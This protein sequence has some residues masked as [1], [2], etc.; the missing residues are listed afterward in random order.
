MSK[1][2]HCYCKFPTKEIVVEVFS[3]DESKL[4]ALYIVGSHLW[5][6]CNKKSDIDFVAVVSDKYFQDET[7]SINCHHGN[8]EAFIVSVSEYQ[9]LLALHSMQVLPTLWL[10]KDHVLIYNPSYL[11]EFKFRKEI[12]VDYLIKTRVRDMDMAEKHFKK[13]NAQKARKVLLHF[14]G[15]L[16][17]SIQIINDGTVSDYT[18]RT[19]YMSMVLSPSITSYDLAT[20]IVFPI[21]EDLMKAVAP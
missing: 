15:Y 9:S 14:I 11:K 17:L 7:K 2:K 13:G 8:Y 18:T 21:I 20:N 5:G 3:I 12:L 19:Q 6:T 1:C 16:L 4:E 10:P